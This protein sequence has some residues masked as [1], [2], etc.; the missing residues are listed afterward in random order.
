MCDKVIIKD[1]LLRFWL[2]LNKNMWQRVWDSHLFLVRVRKFIFLDPFDCTPSLQNNVTFFSWQGSHSFELSK[3]YDFPWPFPWLFPV[4]QDLKFSCQYRKFL[5]SSLFSGI[6]WDNLPVF[7]FVLT[8]T[9]AIIY[10]LHI[11]YLWTT[12]QFHAWKLKYLNSMTFE[13]FHDPYEPCMTRSC[14]VCW[15]VEEGEKDVT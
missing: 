2:N 14:S 11:R 5:K 9:S 6:L 10:V 13:V 4:I 12:I 1:I 15:N 8:S 7:Y 3:F